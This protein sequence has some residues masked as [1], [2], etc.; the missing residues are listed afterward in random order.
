MPRRNNWLTN[1][2]S[3]LVKCKISERYPTV[4]KLRNG[5]VLLLSGGNVVLLDVVVNGEDIQSST[6]GDGANDLMHMYHSLSQ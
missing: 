3:R 5:G 2:L 4:Y 1:V 6:V